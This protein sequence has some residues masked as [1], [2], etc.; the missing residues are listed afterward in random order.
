MAIRLAVL[1]AA[2]LSLAT[3]GLLVA[4]APL[5]ASATGANLL[6]NPGFEEPASAVQGD[7]ILDA[8]VPGWQTTDDQGEFEFW[9][10]DDDS[11]YIELN[12]NS[13]GAVYQDIATTSCD[14]VTWSVD[15]RARMIGVDTMHVLAGAAGGTGADGL[16]VL[17]A[18]TQDGEAITATTE[19]VDETEIDDS[20]PAWDTQWV[21]WG[22]TYQVPEGQTNTRV[23]FKAVSATGWSDAT[24][25]NFIDNVS[26]TVEPGTCPNLA[27][28]GVDAT[29]IGLGG[30]LAVVAGVAGYLVARRRK[31]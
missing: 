25:G 20:D 26:V 27:K 31:A 14:V 16:D 9:V 7:M 8:E 18:T 28:T 2:S 29:P 23:A 22:G 4:S 21:N 6:T 3:A 15:H 17:E 5:T 24:V 11:Q 13:D 12:A 1:R 30:A 19:I 10:H